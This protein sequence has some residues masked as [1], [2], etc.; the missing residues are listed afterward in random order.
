MKTLKE[1]ITEQNF[2]DKKLYDHIR[3]CLFDFFETNDDDENYLLLAIDEYN[4]V[5]K[6]LTEKDLKYDADYVWKTIIENY[7]HLIEETINKQQFLQ[8]VKKYDKQ[9]TKDILEEFKEGIK[10]LKDEMAQNGII[11]I[12]K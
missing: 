8:I 1:Y 3:Y 7:E 4:S 10:D 9:L 2:T 12:K 5:Y 11:N 6:A